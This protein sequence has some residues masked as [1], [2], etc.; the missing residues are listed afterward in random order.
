MVLE[1]EQRY[2]TRL[3]LFRSLVKVVLGYYI[4]NQM[5]ANMQTEFFFTLSNYIFLCDVTESLRV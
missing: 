3:L 4:F 5:G 1:V 2:L